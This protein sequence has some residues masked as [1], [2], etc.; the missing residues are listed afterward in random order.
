MDGVRYFVAN[1]HHPRVTGGQAVTDTQ[2]PADRHGLTQLTVIRIQNRHLAVW[3]L[4]RG[5]GRCYMGCMGVPIRNRH[6][7]VWGL[8]RGMGRCYMGC[9]GVPIRNRHLVVWDLCKGMGRCYMG[10]SVN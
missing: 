6:L 1:G 3:G 4:C 10:L 9:M 2:V 8:C 5:M 7:A